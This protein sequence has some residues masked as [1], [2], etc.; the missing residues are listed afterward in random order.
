MYQLLVIF[1]ETHKRGVFHRS[2]KDEN[3][4]IDIKN[5]Q[6]YLI[7]WGISDFY[8]PGK[9]YEVIGTPNWR[10]PDALMDYEYT[11]YTIDIWKSGM[12]LAG[13]IAK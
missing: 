4:M 5:H 3:V 6:L 9:K 2:P 11:D 12:L 10:S 13:L 1:D 7:D 8:I